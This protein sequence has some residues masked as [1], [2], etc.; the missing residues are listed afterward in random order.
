V[1]R[2][3]AALRRQASHRGIELPTHLRPPKYASWENGY[4]RTACDIPGLVERDLAF[5]AAT[6]TRFIDPALQGTAGA[7]WDP[8]RQAST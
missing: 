2:R 3:T 4:A 5:A 6:A 7:G 8:D 1:V